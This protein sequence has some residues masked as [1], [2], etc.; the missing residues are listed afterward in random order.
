MFLLRALWMLHVLIHL[1]VAPFYYASF[2]FGISWLGY[3]CCELR[4]RLCFYYPDRY[5][6]VFLVY[7]GVV[8]LHLSFLVCCFALSRLFLPS[9]R[10]VLSC[11]SPEHKAVLGYPIWWYSGSPQDPSCSPWKLWPLEASVG[12]KWF[13]TAG[14]NGIRYAFRVTFAPFACK[15]LM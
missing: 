15:V 11:R 14:S 1:W 8:C 7:V 13:C 4:L 10:L 9:L 3:E 12:P 2:L 5:C 6:I